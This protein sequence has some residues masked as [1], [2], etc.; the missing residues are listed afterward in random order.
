MNPSRRLAIG[1]RQHFASLGDIA[2]IYFRALF[3]KNLR[4]IF[5]SPSDA[6]FKCRLDATSLHATARK[7]PNTPKNCESP[8]TNLISHSY[9]VT[10]EEL[11]DLFGKFGPIRQVRQGIANAT[12]GTAFVVYEDVIDAKQACDKLNG[13]NFQNRYLVGTIQPITSPNFSSRPISRISYFTSR[14]AS[15]PPHV[16]SLL[17]HHASPPSIF[18]PHVIASQLTTRAHSIISPA[19]KDGQIKRGPGGSPRVFSEA[20]AAARYRLTI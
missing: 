16:P 6:F 2:N 3:V 9:N 1:K 19:R 4:Y 5:F 11:F 12:K 15:S 20:Q 7:F 18:N 13:F 17:L 10:P 14:I 8:R